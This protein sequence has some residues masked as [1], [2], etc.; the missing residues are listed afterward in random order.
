M[1]RQSKR[2]GSKWRL[3]EG[4]RTLCERKMNR[5]RRVDEENVKGRRS[6]KVTEKG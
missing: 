6:E 3:R 5:D 2:E 4:K 1:R